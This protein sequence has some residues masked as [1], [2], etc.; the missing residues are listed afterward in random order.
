M[1][2]FSTE[3]PVSP[4][5]NK[6]T[7]IAEIIAWLRGSD[8]STVLGAGADADLANENVHLQSPSGDE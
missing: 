2:P 4:K 6:A 3:F 8:Y 5:E 1:F 7:F